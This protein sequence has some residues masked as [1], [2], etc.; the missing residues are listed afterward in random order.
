[1]Q[2]L[3]GAARPHEETA[4]AFAHHAAPSC[5]C[6]RARARPCGVI[7]G[8]LYGRTVAGADLLR[9]VLRRRGPGPGRQAAARRPPRGAR[10][11]P[12]STARC[13]RRP[14]A[15]S[16]AGCW[17]SAPATPD[18]AG[19]AEPARLLLIGGE[20][21]DGP[22]HLWWNFVSSRKERIEQAKADWQ[23][24]GSS[25]V[26][27]ETRVHPSPRLSNAAPLRRRAAFAKRSAMLHINDLTYRIEGRA[28]LRQGDR[29]ASRRR[30]RSASS[31]ATARARRRCSG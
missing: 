8:S 15:S 1:M 23:Q 2:I 6:W 19:G 25:A 9:P 31:A 17:C 28:P 29:R 27:G 3:G 12:A 10:R 7:A 11:L 14:D 30:T 22:R 20:P 4:P 26:P 21:M 13:D 18:H 16:P 5:R 24:G